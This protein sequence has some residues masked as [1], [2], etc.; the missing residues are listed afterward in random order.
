VAAG[1]KK[2]NFNRFEVVQ[3]MK[4]EVFEYLETLVHIIITKTDFADTPY[5]DQVRKYELPP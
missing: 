4:R 1:S 3:S 5:F 2:P